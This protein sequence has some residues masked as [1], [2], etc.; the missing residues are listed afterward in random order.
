MLSQGLQSTLLPQA[1][2]LYSY[3]SEEGG[4]VGED[5][6]FQST[7][8]GELKI[9]VTFSPYLILA[10]QVHHYL[11]ER[12]HWIATSYRDGQVNL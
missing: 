7:G 11:K 12:L 8:I 9:D 2:G 4:F 5:M 10:V 6:F 1:R 3:I